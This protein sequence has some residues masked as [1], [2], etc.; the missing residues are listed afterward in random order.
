MFKKILVALDGL[1]TERNVLSS[2]AALGKACNSKL[3]LVHV[4]SDIENSSML[5][6][7]LS[8]E[9]FYEELRKETCSASEQ[10]LSTAKEKIDSSVHVK[11]LSLIGNP[12]EKILETI[13]NEKAD[14]VILGSRGVGKLSELLLGSTVYKVLHAAKVPVIVIK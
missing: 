1:D 7:S 6:L 10:M 8:F 9:E 14:A 4:I 13:E 12:A 11:T 5:E 2:A 3:V